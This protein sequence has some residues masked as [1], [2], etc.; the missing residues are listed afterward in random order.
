ML[1]LEDVKWT[2][3]DGTEVLKGIDFEAEAGKLTVITGPNGGGKTTIAKVIAG[4]NKITSGHIIMDGA[5][6]A[7]K[8]ITERARMGVAYAFQQPVRFKGITV[9]DMLEIARGEELSDEE[10]YNIM[11]AVG[12]CTEDYIDRE[13]STALSG[14]ESKRIEIAS[15]L[16]RKN[17]KVLIFDEPEAGIDLWSFNGLIDTFETLKKS[18][19]KVL[20][21]ISHQERLLEIADK[22]VVVSDGRVRIE[23]PG[24]DILP[25]LLENE[26]TGCPVGRDIF[27]NLGEEV[28]NG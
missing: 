20:M 27:D 13:V 5:D 2:A 10:I 8:D 24:E 17:A 14:G 22:I 9:R 12:T 19:D 15:V 18:K 23:G 11:A 28:C 4:V 1:R 25:Q 6:I 16:A 3:D 7:D 21:V 26:K